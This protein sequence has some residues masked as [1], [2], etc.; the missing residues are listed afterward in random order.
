MTNIFNMKE[1]AI[2]EIATGDFIDVPGGMSDNI[3]HV[4]T[5][6][7]RLN[8]I[9]L[10]EW[11]DG[12][13]VNQP[14]E[15]EK[16]GEWYNYRDEK[17]ELRANFENKLRHAL[18]YDDWDSFAVTRVLSEIFTVVAIKEITKSSDAE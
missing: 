3:Y 12:Q 17:M 7:I 8:H 5:K 16:I 6:T 13:I 4:E 15:F 1:F 10:D 9:A 2:E 18:G 14:E 11:F